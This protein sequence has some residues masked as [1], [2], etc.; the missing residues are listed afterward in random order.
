MRSA[1]LGLRTNRVAPLFSQAHWACDPTSKNDPLD[2]LGILYHN[3]SVMQRLIHN[4]QFPPP[5][6]LL[7]DILKEVTRFETVTM[8]LVD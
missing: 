4:S 7:K 8:I 3:K 6:L 5:P 2:C 1:G